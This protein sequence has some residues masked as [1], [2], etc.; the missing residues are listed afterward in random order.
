ML[1]FVIFGAGFA[2]LGAVNIFFA[3]RSL[4]TGYSFS[5]PSWT[6]AYKKTNP[7]IYWQ[8]LLFQTFG[9]GVFLIFGAILLSIARH[10][11]L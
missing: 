11:A 1:P 10:Q 2:L 7:S 3:I 9:G 5:G 6:R 4:S 8:N